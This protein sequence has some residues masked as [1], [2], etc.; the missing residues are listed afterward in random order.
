M[1]QQGPGHH[2]PLWGF[3]FFLGLARRGSGKAAGRL[4]HLSAHSTFSLLGFQGQGAH[5]GRSPGDM[6]TFPGTDG[7]SWWKVVF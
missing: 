4:K 2:R 3:C 1:S 7:A 6:L 5:K